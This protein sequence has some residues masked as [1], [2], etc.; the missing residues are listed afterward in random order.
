MTPCIENRP[1][2]T[3]YL[4]YAYSYP[5]KTAYRR[6]PAPVSLEKLWAPENRENLFLYFHLPFCRSR[7]GYCNLFSLSRPGDTIVSD[8][9]EA[10]KLQTETVARAIRPMRI[11]RMAMGGGTPTCLTTSRLGRL[12]DLAARVM[13]ADPSA[14]PGSVEVS[15]DTIDEE[16]AAL[17]DSL[18]VSRISVGIQSFLDRE[19]RALG[20]SQNAADTRR[21]L[22]LLRKTSC[23]LNLDLIYG[24]C[25]QTAESW[26]E[27]LQT[28]MSYQPEELYLYP[29]YVR[30][31]TPLFKRK[32]WKDLRLELYR[33]G[34]DYLSSKGYRQLSMR[35]FRLAG[36]DEEPSDYSC[37]TDGMVGLGCGARSY[38]TFLHYS[39]EYAESSRETRRII[40]AYSKGTDRD[41]SQA[42]HGIRLNAEDRMRRHAIKS[43]LK[44]EG[45]SRL[46]FRRIY[47]KDV[48]QAIPEITELEAAGWMA[49]TSDRV[50]LTP[51]GIERSDAIG[52]W[53]YSEK[54]RRLMEE[55]E[56]R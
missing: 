46:E 43:L 38:T 25:G 21:A 3:T 23:G 28:A 51:S 24:I 20:R 45:I 5:H 35:L 2:G 7:C 30:P 11:S 47:E 49:T 17:F 54:A 18:G 15:P 31:S 42:R 37:Q 32:P 50:F 8:Y 9:L 53:L 10:L 26:L 6:L 12:F 40:Q 56:G 52:P 34:R 29:L 4:S 1:S 14:I 41:F 36:A 39:H 33:I 13:S 44:C 27:S 22:E 16:K 48:C 19:I 55:Y